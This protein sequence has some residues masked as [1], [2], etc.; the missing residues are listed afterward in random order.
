MSK[1]IAR[2]VSRTFQK[3]PLKALIRVKVLKMGVQADTTNLLQ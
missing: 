1:R 2:P 3:R